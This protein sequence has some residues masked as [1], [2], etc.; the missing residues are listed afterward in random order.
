MLSLRHL[1]LLAIIA[2]APFISGSSLA[3]DASAWDGDARSGVRLIAGDEKIENGAKI[4]R[5]G[6]EIRLSPGWKTY[7]RY[8]GDSGVPPNFDFGKSDNVKSVSVRWPAPQL[9][10]DSEG[11][12]IGYKDGV[13]LPL[14]IVPKE[15][16]RPVTLRLNVDY[17]I[18]E[19][20]CVPA[21]ARA[22]LTLPGQP[23]P[24][25][26]AADKL[27]P[28]HSQVGAEGPLS[29]RS[30]TS[31]NGGKLPR[32]LVDVAAPEGAKVQV[33]AE[34]PTPDWALPVPEPVDGAPPGL[35][36]FAFALDGLPTGVS[37]KGAEISITA[38]AGS[39][40]IEATYRLD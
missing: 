18:C 16:G 13:T 37:A 22:E 26:A 39:N 23:S 6:V 31:D 12:T 19:K 29:I 25:L 10:V 24:A 27:V 38:V 8:P 14:A 2:G 4:L 21:Q 11:N 20:L 5:A 36:R 9:F 28:H 40:A 30:V 34:G 7:W 3:A 15:P 33:F 32:L 35:R 1:P 17:A